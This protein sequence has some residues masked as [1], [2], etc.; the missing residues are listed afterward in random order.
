MA[1][2]FT[3]RPD[4][5]APEGGELP[6]PVTLDL[7]SVR[8]GSDE[9]C[10][11]CLQH[12][13]VAP[14]HATLEHRGGLFLLRDEG[15]PGGTVVEGFGR[16]APRVEHPVRTGKVV[17][18]GPVALELRFA[19][20][21]EG[22][23]RGT[24][25]MALRLVDEVFAQGD[26]RDVVLTVSEGP[27]RGQQLR[28]RDGGSYVIGRGR[29]ADLRLEDLDVS[30]HHVR[31]S[32]RGRDVFA[33]DL[34][35]SNGTRLGASPLPREADAP[36]PAGE[37]LCLGNTALEHEAALASALRD[38]EGS[39]ASSAGGP[40]RDGDEDATPAPA[41]VGNAGSNEAPIASAPSLAGA[42]LEKVAAPVVEAPAAGAAPR[43]EPKA[44]RFERLMTWVFLAAAAAVL[45]M[46]ALALW[47]AFGT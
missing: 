33:R 38:L 11:L 8:I 20:V 27:N 6:P 1:V 18:F 32:V 45:A 36:W 42:A 7:P 43:A 40:L 41:E 13:G 9:A 22:T 14:H 21:G 39:A 47:W 23:S 35:S 25:K 29:D 46:G 3:F 31:V 4:G 26:V 37:R 10:E 12:P 2:T 30:R 19:S 34:G 5:A 28:V 17:R 16:I 44:D 24:M 15:S